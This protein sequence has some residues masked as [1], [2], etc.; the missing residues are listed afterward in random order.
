MVEW[1]LTIKELF[2]H[3]QLDLRTTKWGAHVAETQNKC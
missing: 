3:S 1:F 2:F